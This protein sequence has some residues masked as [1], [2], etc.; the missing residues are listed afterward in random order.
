MIF[1]MVDGILLKFLEIK[2]TYILIYFKQ[3]KLIQNLYKTI[4]T[5]MI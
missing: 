3:L 4:I 1:V 2:G 5:F